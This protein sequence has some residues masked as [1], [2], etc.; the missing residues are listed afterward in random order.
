MAMTKNQTTYTIEA[1]EFKTSERLAADIEKAIE[2][3]NNL[4]IPISKSIEFRPSFANNTYGLAY[5]NTSNCKSGKVGEQIIKNFLE[6][7][8]I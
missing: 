7:K 6:I 4:N 8:E 5:R 3:C 1:Y 2:I